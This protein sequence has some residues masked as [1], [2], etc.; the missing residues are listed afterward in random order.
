MF[1]VRLFMRHAV[2]FFLLLLMSTTM[3]RAAESVP[4]LLLAITGDVVEVS[5][6]NGRIIQSLPLEGEAPDE[7]NREYFAIV[8]DMNFDG[9][10]DVRILFSRGMANVYFDCWLW[11]PEENAFVRRDDMRELSNPVFDR[12]TRVVR[13]YERGSAV[14]HAK[15]A[16]TWENGELV[17]LSQTVR[18]A[19]DDGENIVVRRYLRDGDGEL[20]L[21]GEETFHPD[22][23]DEDQ[24]DDASLP[25]ELSGLNLVLDLVAEPLDA[26][27]LP[28]G[29]WWLY[30]G[31]P[32][33]SLLIESRRLPPLEYAGETLHRLVHAEWP[34]ARDIE[35][36]PFPALTEKTS[37][38]A[39]KAE[40]LIGENED[41]RQFVAALVFADEW[42][43]WFVLNASADTELSPD[44]G[45]DEAVFERG[46]R[47]KK[48]M[49]AALLGVKP[50]ECVFL[51]GF[52][53]DFYLTGPDS[54]LPISVM[55]ALIRIK[56]IV[57]PEK[58]QWLEPGW[59]AYRYDGP[60]T[61][62]GN[63]ALCFS[64]GADTPEKFTAERHF[65]VDAEGSVFEMDI[66]GGGEY[67]QW[68]EHG[69]SWWGE[70]RRGDTL[71]RI[72]NYREGPFGMYFIF[73]FT[74]GE[75]TVFGG[76]APVRGR[77]AHYG[78]LVFSLAGDDKM[79]AV[80][81]NPEA[82][83]EGEPVPGL[84]GTYRAE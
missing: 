44:D 16:L 30:Q 5:D 31:A 48:D 67:W 15:G 35:V 60:G 72:H 43:F 73:A 10:P 24:I 39:F 82:A 7:N 64:F 6:R 28:N 25:P 18:D 49:E 74:V 13:V 17:W 56:K 40:F 78:P 54:T 3:S 76:T 77:T 29:E 63:P 33:R 66:P 2:H 37:Y 38:P 58:S 81:A 22:E 20:R 57:G 45:A 11:R 46:G 65:A 41:T 52:V 1:P 8:E 69:A 71:L 34:L 55:D 19:A 26:A 14:C 84:E 62:A 42:S 59:V 36:A 27:V 9:N 79:I 80:T 51:P 68:D 47:L 12:E 4:E 61:V 21:V 83:W 75:K 32:D 23:F 70:Y 50:A 53:P